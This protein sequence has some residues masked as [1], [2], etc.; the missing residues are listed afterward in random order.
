[1]NETL[2]TFGRGVVKLL[3]SL[4]VGTGIGLLTF[5]IASKDIENIWY[6]PGPPSEFFLAVGAGLLST[7]MMMVLLFFLP[8]LWKGPAPAARK[9][10]AYEE[11]P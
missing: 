3:V 9:G 11:L 10:P 6:R 1:M 4:F 2:L 7:G 5:G 8:R